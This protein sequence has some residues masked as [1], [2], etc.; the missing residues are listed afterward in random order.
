MPVLVGWMV[1]LL[2]SASAA[3]LLALDF[4]VDDGGMVS[5]GDPMQWEWGE[6]AEDMGPGAGLEGPH[7]WATRLDAP[8]MNDADDHLT[9]PPLDLRGAER[10][11]LGLVHWYQIA[12]PGDLGRLEWWTGDAWMPL[13]PVYGYPASG[14]FSGDSQGWDSH[15]F[16][17][18]GIDDA[19]DVRLR[20]TS[21]VAVAAP[22]WVLGTLTIEDGDPIPP[23]IDVV[24]AP[25]DTSSLDAPHEVQVR[26][27]DDVAVGTVTLHWIV[28]GG[29]RQEALMTAT[30]DDRWLGRIPLQQPGSTVLWWV[31][32][33]D[34]VN[35]ATTV[36]RSFRVFLPAPTGLQ[37]PSDRVI[38]Q[39]ARLSWEPPASPYTIVDYRVWREDTVVATVAEAMADA[40]LSGPVDTFAVSARF[41]T[42]AGTF[43][44]DRSAAVRV[45]ASVPQVTAVEPDR[46]WQG[47]R[48]RVSITG[49]YLLFAEHDLSVSLGAGTLVDS[50]EVLDAATLVATVAVDRAATTGP[51][52]VTI[53]SGGL[54]VDLPGGFAVD[55]GATRPR[56][57]ALTPDTIILGERRTLVLAFSSPPAGVPEL[58][59]GEGIIVETIR[60]LYEDGRSIEIRVAA[61]PD[62]PTGSHRVVADDGVRLIEGATLKVSAPTRT[63]GRVCA[64]APGAVPVGLVGMLAFAL[65]GRRRDD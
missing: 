65:A 22:G 26:V 8:T 36:P 61:S 27:Q 62:A 11:V 39:T 14:G 24:T 49:E 15:W 47:D 16:E 45:I 35:A 48:V 17:L 41:D 33:S 60:P 13:D 4:S 51:R 54:R 55:D 34:G 25:V 23:R 40:P 9:L 64:A 12:A 44:G 31:E 37:G 32:A 30:F 5:G 1:G 6:V 29:S 28:D 58:N 59:L 46:A 63:A 21:D 53:R 43:E 3:P 10:P 7:A 50:I 2:T 52:T 38:G 18:A 56:I 42:P 57:R 19:A 20:F